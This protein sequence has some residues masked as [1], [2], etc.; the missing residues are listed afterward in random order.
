MSGKSTAKVDTEENSI[1]INIEF[2]DQGCKDL[3]IS[4]N[5]KLLNK[6][7]SSDFQLGE[8]EVKYLL[9]TLNDEYKTYQKNMNLRTNVFAAQFFIAG[10]SIFLGQLFTYESKSDTTNFIKN[11][12]GSQLPTIFGAAG[13]LVTLI[14]GYLNYLNEK[15]YDDCSTEISSNVFKLN[16]LNIDKE[17]IQKSRTIDKSR[18]YFRKPRSYSRKPNNRSRFHSES[19]NSE[20][21]RKYEI[22][23]LIDLYITSLKQRN[24]VLFRERFIDIIVSVLFFLFILSISYFLSLTL[25]GGNSQDY[26]LDVAKFLNFF[27][28]FR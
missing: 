6:E 24:R 14:T 2:G 15:K 5:N 3:E 9:L 16:N 23:S 19:N 12:G 17:F 4:L 13:T 11:I 27:A 20:D 25:Q 10:F 18:S 8:K 7:D 28:T 1:K 21:S 26:I 22:S